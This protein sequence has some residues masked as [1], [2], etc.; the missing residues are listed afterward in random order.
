MMIKWL[1]S[2]C[3]LNM[4]AAF[5]YLFIPTHPLP[6][7]VSEFK[8]PCSDHVWG[9][10]AVRWD[11]GQFFDGTGEG[12]DLITMQH[13]ELSLL[14][15]DSLV[16]WVSCEEGSLAGKPADLLYRV[17][18]ILS[19]LFLIHLSVCAWT[20]THIV[21]VKVDNNSCWL[22]VCKGGEHCWRRSSEVFWSCTYPQEH[23]TLSALQQRAHSWSGP[24][25]TK[26]RWSISVYN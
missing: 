19:T 7:C 25:H 8:E 5:I 23:N 6:P 2:V 3:L 16:P 10:E 14:T 13:G 18:T 17:H 15:G 24:R 26:Y 4:K 21:F 12:K 11:L 20:N 1:A 9:G 22:C